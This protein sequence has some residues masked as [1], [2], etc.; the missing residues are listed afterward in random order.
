MRPTFQNGHGSSSHFTYQLARH[1]LSYGF[2]WLVEQLHG[3]VKFYFCTYLLISRS[4]E[5]NLRLVHSVLLARNISLRTIIINIRSV[6]KF[7]EVVMRL[8]CF[9]IMLVMFTELHRIAKCS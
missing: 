4:E 8:L 5:L 9:R 2:L 7:T 3:C 6:I 1:D